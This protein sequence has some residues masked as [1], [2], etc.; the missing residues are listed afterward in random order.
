LDGVEVVLSESYEGVRQAIRE[1][2]GEV[3]WQPLDSQEDMDTVPL[4]LV[5]AISTLLLDARRDVG[6]LSPRSSL[7]ELFG[8]DFLSAYTLVTVNQALSRPADAI[9]ITLDDAAQLAGSETT[10]IEFA[11]PQLALLHQLNRPLAA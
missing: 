4:P 3:R 6:S 2:L 8:R 9:G 1:V 10:T 5:S 11:V 7:M